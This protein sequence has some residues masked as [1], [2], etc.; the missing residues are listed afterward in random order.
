MFASGEDAI[1]EDTDALVVPAAA[2]RPA[3]PG[4]KANMPTAGREE[5]SNAGDRL[6]AGSLH[7]V[8]ARVHRRW[9]PRIIERVN[10]E[11]RNA[12]RSK[13]WQC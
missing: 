3:R 6:R 2:F 5:H 13:S 1:E 7:G 12:D 4:V 11:S 10:R 9:N 8:Q